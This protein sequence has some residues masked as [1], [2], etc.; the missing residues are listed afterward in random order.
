MTTPGETAVHLRVDVFGEMDMVRVRRRSAPF[1][2]HMHDEY[3]IGVVDSGR[4]RT[5]YRGSVPSVGAGELFVVQAGEP[6]GGESDAAA[7]GSADEG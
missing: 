3:V 1:P 7:G 4:V 5:A 2:I 6:H